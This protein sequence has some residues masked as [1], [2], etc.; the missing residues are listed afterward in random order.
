M[1]I[2]GSAG[3]IIILHEKIKWKLPQRDKI[4]LRDLILSKQSIF[5]IYHIFVVFK[6][7]L[8]IAKI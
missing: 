3:K 2:I 1:N 8:Y 5:E 4:F 7:Q 6:L